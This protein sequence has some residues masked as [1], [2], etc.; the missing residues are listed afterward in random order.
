[1]SREMLILMSNPRV[2]R[3]EARLFAQTAQTDS[4]KHLG[5]GKDGFTIADSQERHRKQRE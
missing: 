2:F 5:R 3:F 1:M 4:G